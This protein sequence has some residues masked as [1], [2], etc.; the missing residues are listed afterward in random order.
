M[1]RVCP[2]SNTIPRTHNT[3]H[4]PNQ[5]ITPTSPFWFSPLSGMVSPSSTLSPFISDCN[6]PAADEQELRVVTDHDAAFAGPQ[7]GK[8][9]SNSAD[10]QAL[11]DLLEAPEGYGN[12]PFAAAPP[13]MSEDLLLALG[14]SCPTSVQDDLTEEDA[15]FLDDLLL[16]LELQGESMDEHRADRPVVLGKGHEEEKGKGKGSGGAMGNIVKGAV[17]G[18]LQVEEISVIDDEPWKGGGDLF[19]VDASLRGAFFGTAVL[20]EHYFYL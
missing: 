19:D 4:P 2:V 14:D 7:G 6:L 13:V 16:G 12:D 1:K 9:N 18:K 15:C 5:T 10:E 20:C 8:A 17:D 11:L 3:T